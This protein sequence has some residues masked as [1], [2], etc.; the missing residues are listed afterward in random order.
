METQTIKQGIAHVD[1]ATS[2]EFTKYVASLGGAYVFRGQACDWW[3][4][5]PSLSNFFDESKNGVYPQD[6]YDLTKK[7]L[8]WFREGLCECVHEVP[9]LRGCNPSKLGDMDLWTIGRHYGLHTP[10]LDWTEDASIAAFF[11]FDQERKEKE[12]QTY[13][14]RA[15]WAAERELINRSFL[16]EFNNPFTHFRAVQFFHSKLDFPRIHKQRGLLSFGPALG[17]IE[18]RIQSVFQNSPE[19]A[20]IRISIPDDPKFCCEL[21]ISKNDLFAKSEVPALKKLVEKCRREL[22]RLSPRS[23]C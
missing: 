20:L 18:N 8:A 1:V 7:L 21:N 11:A 2:A 10:I 9:F 19:V 16:A 23:P 6:A 3:E 5:R 13:P 22:E 4:L 15:V 12:D 14:R 17:A